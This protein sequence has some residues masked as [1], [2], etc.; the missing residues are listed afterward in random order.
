MKKINLLFG[1]TLIILLL[2]GINSSTLATD[3]DQILNYVVTVD[4]RMNDGTLDITYEFTWKVLDSTSEG[5]LS[6]VQIGTPNEHFDNVKAVT[7]NIKSIKKY[8]GSYVRIDFKKSYEAGEEITFKYSIH[9]LYVHGASNSKCTYKFTPA[10]FTNIKV[11]NLKIKWNADEVVKHDAISKEDNYL[12]WSRKN[13]AKGEK[14]TANV[15]YD[16]LSLGN[17]KN[18][19]K[20]SSSD[21]SGS[22]GFFVVI[23]IIL[24][25]ISSISGGGYGGGRGFYGGYR[26]GYRSSG[27]VRSSCACACAC[28]RSCACACA[29]SGRAGC[30]KKDFYG[31]KL[32]KKK[33]EKV[34][35]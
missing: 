7:N 10:W 30:S 9:Q 35:K 3:L 31:T 2:L 22:V 1:I 29:G 8:N 28:A 25:L 24:S 32:T 13:L 12:V 26:S 21:I 18:Y 19:S 20:S 6:W 23:I 34:L 16:I 33:L 27:C 14:L 15:E 5:P 17:L 11:D 4:P